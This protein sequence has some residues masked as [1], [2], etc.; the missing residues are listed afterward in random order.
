MFNFSEWLKIGIIDGYKK[1]LTPF[2]RVTEITA[3][4]Y[5]KGFITEAQVQEIMDECPM[6][7]ETGDI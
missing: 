5:S 6:Q 2:S 1:G 3:T 7:E 4:Y